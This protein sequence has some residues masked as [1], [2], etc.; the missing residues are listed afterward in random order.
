MN[1]V[2]RRIRAYWIPFTEIQQLT[3]TSKTGICKTYNYPYSLCTLWN[4]ALS[5]LKKKKKKGNARVEHSSKASILKLREKPICKRQKESKDW[6]R[7]KNPAPPT[8]AQRAQNPPDHSPHLQVLL[9]RTTGSELSRPAVPPSPPVS[10]LVW[11]RGYVLSTE[12]L[13]L[14][15]CLRTE[16]DSCKSR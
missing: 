2:T 15:R 8:F 10:A 7:G 6:I 16:L 5:S 11:E 3:F 13:P 4:K 14:E 9:P 12:G 1:Q